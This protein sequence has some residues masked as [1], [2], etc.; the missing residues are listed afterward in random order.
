MDPAEE[1]ELDG[2]IPDDTDEDPAEGA[3]E[4][5]VEGSSAPALPELAPDIEQEIKNVL[6]MDADL[7]VSEDGLP[8]KAKNHQIPRAL[9]EKPLTLP[10]L[11]DEGSI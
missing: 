4:V 9:I 11:F 2:D 10:D 8:P 6:G 3:V 5:G 7:I 1:P